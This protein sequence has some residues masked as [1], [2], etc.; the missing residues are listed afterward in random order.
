MAIDFYR[1][2]G[3]TVFQRVIQLMDDGRFEDTTNDV[4]DNEKVIGQLSM[5]ERGLFSYILHER[6]H[7]DPLKLVRNIAIH[8]HP[9]VEIKVLSQLLW[10][11]IRERLNKTLATV[12]GIRKGFVIVEISPAPV[13]VHK[14]DK[15]ACGKL[16]NSECVNCAQFDQCVDPKQA[17]QA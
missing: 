7:I 3:G 15:M 14:V 16:L 12:M 2:F 1:V 6:D 10:F 4:A 11:M 5:F 13:S 8:G 9:T 17:H